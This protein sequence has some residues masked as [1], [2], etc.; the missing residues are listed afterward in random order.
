MSKVFIAGDHRVEAGCLRDC[1][2]VAVYKRAPAHLESR[3][4]LVIAE[5]LL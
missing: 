2:Q 3:E 4:D 5:N 1:Q